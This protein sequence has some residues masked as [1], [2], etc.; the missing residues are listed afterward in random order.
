MKNEAIVV[1]NRV[2]FS[3]T[4]SCNNACKWC[5]RSGSEEPAFLDTQFV[6]KT[7]DV[8][9]ESGVKKCTIIGG[10]P[11]LHKDYRVIMEH[12]AQQMLSCTLVTNGRTLPSEI[13]AIWSTNPKIHIVVSLHGADRGHYRENTGSDDG[14][15]QATS[16]IKSLV[17]AKVNHSVNVVVS[18][19]NLSRINDFVVVV[20]SLKANTLC[21]TMAISS[22]DDPAYLTDPVLI[23]GVV[24]QIHAICQRLKQPHIFI[25][26]LP[27][28]LLPGVLLKEL[29]GSR[30]LMFNC[31]VDQGRGI[32]VKESGAVAV[33]THLSSYEVLS[34]A[35]AK[36]VFDKAKSFIDFWNSSEF[37]N[38]RNIVNV[39]RYQGC[40][41]CPYSDYCK[42]GCPLWWKFFDFRQILKERR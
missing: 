5:Y 36:M 32:V 16:A 25:F 37:K 29:I 38:F 6:L 15:K 28:C 27:W 22:I 10:E 24:P 42:G 7:I 4:G 40:V 34:S 35:E 23:A 12:A 26:S 33:C 20:S 18:K 11:T 17:S 19:E 2:W 14:F 31:P 13:P 39:H 8:F 21:F 9:S 1:P 30:Q 3:L 41:A